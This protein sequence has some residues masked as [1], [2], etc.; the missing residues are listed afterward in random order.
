MVQVLARR[1]LNLGETS[2]EDFDHGIL[3]EGEK[4]VQL[5]SLYQLVYISSFLN[6]ENI[7][8]FFYK[9]SYPDEEV[10]CT[11]PSPSV[12][13]PCFDFDQLALPSVP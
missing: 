1:R 10:N 12:S 6:I 7:V 3:T 8:Y 5:N 4:A 2:D 9:T 11:E 13:V